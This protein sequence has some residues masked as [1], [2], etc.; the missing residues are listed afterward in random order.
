MEF[1]IALIIIIAIAIL[2]LDRLKGGK[3]EPSFPYIQKKSLL[4]P[5]ERSFFGVL[6]SATDGQLEIFC[7]VRLADIIG[8]K[9]GLEKSERQSAFN[10]IKAKHIDFVLCAPS[11]LKILAAIELDDKSHNQKKRMERDGFINDVFKEVG[12]SLIR[13]K[14]KASYSRSEI[15]GHLSTWLKV[16]EKSPAQ[17]SMHTEKIVPK[18]DISQA[19]ARLCPKCSSEMVKR[20]ALKG[21]HAGE[22][23]L[24]CSGYPKCRT[25]LPIEE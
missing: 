10:K 12:I 25:I 24:A 9:K 20:K 8:L 14:A 5:A 2:M 19:K 1:V 23:F 15:T 22:Y 18:Q 6:K 16:D 11:D 7:Q 3:S 21:K 17:Q 13:F 4:S